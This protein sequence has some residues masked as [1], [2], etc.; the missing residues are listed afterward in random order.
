MAFGYWNE[1]SDRTHYRTSI[2]S[3]VVDCLTSLTSHATKGMQHALG[4]WW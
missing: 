4:H 1:E 3:F 2:I